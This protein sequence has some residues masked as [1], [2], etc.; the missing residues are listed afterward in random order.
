MATEGTSWGLLATREDFHVQPH[1][2]QARGAYPFVVLGGQA[3]TNTGTSVLNG[4]LGVAPGT[5][6]AGFDTAVVNG[7]THNNDAVAHQAQ[8]DLT[9]A[10]NVAAG[11]ATTADLSNT[12][13]GNRTLTAGAYKYSSD[14]QLTGPLTLDAQNNPDA[15]FVFQITSQLTTASGP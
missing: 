15:Q 3:A 14:A 7:A 8:A 12:D 2:S 1:P 13:L 10:Y 11:Q 6:L 9:T 4:N 5:S